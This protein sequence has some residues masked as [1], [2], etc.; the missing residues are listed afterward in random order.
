M[1]HAP[2]RINWKNVAADSIGTLHGLGASEF[3]DLEPR[4]KAAT[5]ALSVE[6]ESNGLRFL[7]LPSDSDMSAA[8]RAACDAYASQT[9]N[10][11]VLGIGGS[12]LGAVALHNALNRPFYNLVDP[13]VRKG[14]RLFVMDN[15]DP[16]EFGALL[17]WLESRL[18]DTLFCVISKSGET[19]E[20]AA[21]FMIVRRM[22]AET[23]GPDLAR[24]RILII[25]DPD[26]GPLRQ[27][28]IDEGYQSLSVPPGVGGRFSI[29]SPV[30]LF[31]AA[32][33][34][35][36]VESILA[37]ARR[38][39]DLILKSK[40]FDSPAALVAA[41]HFLMYQKGK[42]LSVMMPYS[43]RLS[44]LTDWW[45]QL[46]GESL[47]KRLDLQSDEVF[48]GPTPIRATGATDQHSQIQLF[49]EGPNDK[50]IT[51]LEVERFGRDV[52]I[53]DELPDAETMQ[54]LHRHSL[55]KLLNVEKMTTEY[56]LV[57]SE[58][59][60]MTI[61]FPRV[62]PHAVGQ[63]IVLYETAA[64]ILARLFNINPFDQ[65]A[66]ELGKTGTFAMMGRSGYENLK[67]KIEP[68]AEKDERF[69]L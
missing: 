27:I 46:W 15:V 62:T 18:Q 38:M 39:R 44:G 6:Y 17:D 66:V 2:I 50:L 40:L 23:L 55:G 58:R 68:T 63:F 14:P 3:K 45:R 9:S 19:A 21:Q 4:I 64:V 28:A 26:E 11:V 37:G 51:F 56:A 7:N 24:D 10:L 29:L 67:H 31:S 32:M 22:L 69:L 60:S 54:Y 42:P 25:T 61:S 49:R 41:I 12:A 8:V 35:I 1:G 16:E 52:A 5:S 43:S 65:P 57:E 59:P 36:D 33:C 34:G 53:P 47:G 30:A 20:T 13:D 48:V